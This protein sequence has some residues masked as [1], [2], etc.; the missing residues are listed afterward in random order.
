MTDAQLIINLI[1]CGCII[2]VSIFLL[3]LIK[4]NPRKDEKSLARKECLRAA[5]ELARIRKDA[6]E[7]GS[8]DGKRNYSKVSRS[9]NYARRLAQQIAYEDENSASGSVLENVQN[10]RDI[11]VTLRRA[12]TQQE[13]E[14][15]ALEAEQYLEKAVKL[16]DD[17]EE[18]VKVI[19][20]KR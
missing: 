18:T 2:V 12:A 7:G 6:S 5:A 9:L 14:E 10:A 8:A 16:I 17:I 1:V 20:K 3:L 4:K 11:C 13:R 15:K 19:N